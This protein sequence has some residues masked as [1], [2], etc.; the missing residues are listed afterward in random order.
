MSNT[1]KESTITVGVQLDEK[2]VPERI[3]WTATDSTAD[4]MQQARAMMLNFWDAEEKAALRIDL[5]TKDMMVDEMIDFYY[6]CLMG[7]ADSLSRSTG[8]Q[9]LVDDMKKFA[10]GFFKKFQ[11]LQRNGQ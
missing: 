6:Q 2:K 5:W 4:D 3:R 9:V 1:M 11:E 8:Q 10:A 7:M